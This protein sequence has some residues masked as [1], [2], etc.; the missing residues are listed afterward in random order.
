MEGSGEA[1]LGRGE[2]ESQHRPHE[3]RATLVGSPPSSGEHC[4]GVGRGGSVGKPA[5][6]LPSSALSSQRALVGLV[7]SSVGLALIKPSVMVGS[8]YGA[9]PRPWDDAQASHLHCLLQEG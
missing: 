2:A 3:I 5:P 1:G 9:A 7:A 8:A 4:W 6:P